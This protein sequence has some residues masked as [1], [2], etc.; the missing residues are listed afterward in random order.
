MNK[1]EILNQCNQ[2]L[3]T[4]IEKRVFPR[5][6]KKIRIILQFEYSPVLYETC[7][8]DL[9][10]GGI[11]FYGNGHLIFP[12]Q[13]IKLSI[14]LPESALIGISGQVSWNELKTKKKKAGI[15]F[16]NVSQT[17]QNNIMLFGLRYNANET[18]DTNL[19]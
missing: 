4:R 9:S 14:F 10:C 15:K 7:T 17:V 11:C 2:S 18:D 12:G 19:S 5:W 6:R 13:K 1:L 16:L 3:H 8:K